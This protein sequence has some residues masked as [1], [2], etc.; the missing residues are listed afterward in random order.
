M[1][2][3]T[4]RPIKRGA[5][6]AL[7]TA[8][9]AW[10]KGR[11]TV[12]GI[13]TSDSSYDTLTVKLAKEFDCRLPLRAR[14]GNG[15]TVRV[16]RGDYISE[17]IL[18]HGY[19]E[20]DTVA[21]FHRYLKPGMTVLDIG[22][23]I[24]QYTMVASLLVGTSGH[25]HSFEPDPD[26]FA[27][28]RRN[29]R[30]NGLGNVTL[31]A[32]ALTEA[33]TIQTFYFSYGEDIGSN[34]LAEPRFFSGRTAQ[35]QCIRLADYIR[36]R[37]LDRV[38]FVKMDVEGAELGVLRGGGDLFEGTAR[39]ILVME[40]EEERQRAFGQSCATLGAW[41][42]ARGYRLFRIGPELTPYRPSASDPRSLNILGL[43]E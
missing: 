28:L 18:A 3:V 2:K 33:P 14:L 32:L 25:V 20:P 38:H 22:A 29:C 36:T 5:R 35:V 21:L 13:P 30:D 7:R 23:H 12:F 41:L 26:T 37:N 1:L 16:A 11:T 6:R 4:P 15:M 43:P 27:L 17:H 10:I 39:P 40:F 9:Q 34:S 19:Y 31:N 8:V 24:G 42:T